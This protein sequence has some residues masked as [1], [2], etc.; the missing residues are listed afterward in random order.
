MH[1]N[2]EKTCGPKRNMKI[3]ESYLKRKK[4]CTLNNRANQESPPRN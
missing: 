1:W 4:K 3:S 2:V